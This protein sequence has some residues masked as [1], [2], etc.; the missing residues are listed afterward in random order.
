[1]AEFG[2]ATLCGTLYPFVGP[3][4]MLRCSVPTWTLATSRVFRD[5]RSFM[6]NTTS[7]WA[8]LIDLDHWIWRGVKGSHEMIRRTGTAFLWVKS[9]RLVVSNITFRHFF[10]SAKG[11]GAN[12]VARN[13]CPRRISFITFTIRR[14]S[15]AP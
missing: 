7:I 10:F 12:P 8:H 1:M 4:V 13:T 6:L 14:P 11:L 15:T 9:R 3:Y 5:W 2:A